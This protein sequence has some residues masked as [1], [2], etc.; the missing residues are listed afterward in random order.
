MDLDEAVEQRI[1][2]DDPVGRWLNFH[3][4]LS[5]FRDP[6]TDVRCFS[7]SS[8]D[9][10]KFRRKHGLE[11]GRYPRGW[12][13]KSDKA[14]KEA[15]KDACERFVPALLR[16]AV[17]A[18]L[19]PSI[20]AK[21]ISEKSWPFLRQ[22]G[23]AYE[24]DL[25]QDCVTGHHDFWTASSGKRG[26]VVVVCPPG[27]LAP[28]MLAG[29]AEPAVMSSR[30]QIRKGCS[31]GAMDYA[32]KQADEGFRCFVF[33]FSNGVEHCDLYP[34]AGK[35]AD[36]LLALFR[37]IHGDPG[38]FAGMPEKAFWQFDDARFSEALAGYDIDDEDDEDGD[39]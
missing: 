31:S 28:E 12:Q 3:L 13:A 26:T 36:D 37:G 5:G 4:L 34:P 1:A 2:K 15:K 19:Y 6:D 10:R 11:R 18:R 24:L 7:F 32:R 14:D 29:C 25:A 9:D 8:Y 21:A 22:S 17:S 27:P 30:H 35:E 33:S 39:E 20:D 16:S 23:R 38:Y